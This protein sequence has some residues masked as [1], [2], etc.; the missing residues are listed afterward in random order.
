MLT[1]NETMIWKCSSKIG[2]TRDL[3]GGEIFQNQSAAG[4]VIQSI[5]IKSLT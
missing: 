5:K 2:D 1:I 3:G 4:N